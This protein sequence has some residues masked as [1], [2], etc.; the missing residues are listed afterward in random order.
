MQR[1]FRPLCFQ[2]RQAF[3]RECLLLAQRPDQAI[4]LAA[5][6]Q[7]SQRLRAQGHATRRQ[8]LRAGGVECGQRLGGTAVCERELRHRDRARGRVSSC[9][10]VEM[11]RD[12]GGIAPR[13][14]GT[15]RTDARDRGDVVLLGR[16]RQ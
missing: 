14:R 4:G 12:G 9:E 7:R 10:Y 8:W 16:L 15:G 5:A 13:R 6:A 1:G 2:Y 11:L 3:G